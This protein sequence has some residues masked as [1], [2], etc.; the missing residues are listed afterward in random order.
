MTLEKLSYENKT[1]Q[2]L[3]GSPSFGKTIKIIHS[4]H[5]ML[6]GYRFLMAKILA[7]GIGYSNSASLIHVFIKS[8]LIFYILTS[9]KQ[10][11][12]LKSMILS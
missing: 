8:N 9:L 11:C 6:L 5:R 2:K 12:F 7:W 4:Y 1:K 3:E 10:R